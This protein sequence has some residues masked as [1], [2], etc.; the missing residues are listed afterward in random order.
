MGKTIKPMTDLELNKLMAEVNN[1]R[2]LTEDE[3]NVLLQMFIDEFGTQTWGMSLN[4]YWLLERRQRQKDES[5]AVKEWLA[6]DELYE[7]DEIQ[8]EA[9][10]IG[11]GVLCKKP[12]NCSSFQEYGFA[13]R[14]IRTNFNSRTEFNVWR[15]KKIKELGND[16]LDLL[17]TEH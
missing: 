8:V 15:D 17:P 4:P 13:C 14:C 1:D 10:D 11:I 12:K 5:N 16:L 2:P 9:P 6:R 7:F 3:V